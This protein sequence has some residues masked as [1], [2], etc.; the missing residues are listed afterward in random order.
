MATMTNIEYNFDSINDEF[1]LPIFYNEKKIQLN[2]QI[3]NDLE[4]IQTID[5]SCVPIYNSVFKPK[6]EFSKKIIE[7]S[8]H[9]YTTDT[10]FLKDT[11]KMLAAYKCIKNVPTNETPSEFSNYE[12]I[13]T[14]WNDVKTDTGFKNRYCYMD[15]EFCEF[16]N[17]NELFLQFISI[18]NLASPVISFFIPVVILIIPFFIIKIKG[19]H[20]SMG[21]YL[22]VLKTI[23]AS[24][25]IGRIFTHFNKVSMDQK[26][27]ILVSAF[28]YLFS[29][30]QNILICIRFNQNMKKVH[31]YLK[32]IRSYINNTLFTMKHYLEFSKDLPS[33]QAFNDSIIT[34]MNTLETYKAKVD[35][36]A[37]PFSYSFK[38]IGEI[39]HVLKCFYEFYCNSEYNSA[40]LFSF[41]FKF[42]FRFGFRFVLNLFPMSILIKINKTNKIN[43][44]LISKNLITQI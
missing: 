18:Y 21:E 34:N 7:Q 16:L 22:E 14:A 20:I 39:G 3:I 43:N 6:T 13:L 42:G 41:G 35:K 44:V 10:H 25:A 29:I 4:L 23:A 11:Q 12:D 17:K 15:W 8:A 32:D 38:K 19:L 2:K 1:K 40:F 36:I 28:F 37:Q 31:T 5:A 33:Y 9:F 26:V 24:H 27:Y 30:Y